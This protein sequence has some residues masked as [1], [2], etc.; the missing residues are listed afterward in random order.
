MNQTQRLEIEAF[1]SELATESEPLL[2]VPNSG[3]A[4]D[5][6]IGHAT[7]QLFDRLGLQYECL[8]DPRGVDPSGPTDEGRGAVGKRNGW[9]AISPPVLSPRSGSLLG[10]SRRPT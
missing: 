1:L 2:Y 8:A 9:R 5:S 10:V 3:N 4:G 6:L 7:F